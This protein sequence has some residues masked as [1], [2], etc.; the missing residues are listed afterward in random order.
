MTKRKKN[1]LKKIIASLVFTLIA[2][3][4][5]A[6]KDRF[7][8]HYRWEAPSEWQESARELPAFPDENTAWLAVD[9]RPSAWTAAIARD[10]IVVGDTDGVVQFALRHTSPHGADNI[11]VQ[12]LRC[13]AASFQIKAIARPAEQRWIE[14][15]NKIWRKINSAHHL[16]WLLARDYFC[17]FA[18]PLK[19]D[20]ILRRLRAK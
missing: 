14:S 9:L 5:W 12:S 4:A 17:D 11:S 6:D 2:S 1:M 10:S 13:D 20:E 8:K 18:S 16:Q 7:N 15:Q 19:Q 3:Q